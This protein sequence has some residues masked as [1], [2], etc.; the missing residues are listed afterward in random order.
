MGALELF[1]IAVG[2]S[3]D[4]FAVAVAKGLSV[5]QLKINHVITV[6]LYFGIFQALMPLLG[7]LV[8]STFASFITSV[9][10]WVVFVLLALIGANMIRE[11]QKKSES[12]DTVNGFT[13]KAMLPFALATSVD[14]LAIGIAFASL[15][16]KIMP[17]IMLIGVITFAFSCLGVKIGNVFGEKYKSTAELAGGVILILLG[18]KVLVEHF[19]Y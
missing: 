14:A 8:G 13:F 16:V 17:A 3:M 1:L 9:D 15:Q 10:H 18:V 11:S 5:T 7:Y 2:L 12:E 4:A 19:L 6:G